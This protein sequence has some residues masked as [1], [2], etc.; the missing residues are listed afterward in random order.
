MR[1]PFRSPFPALLGVFAYLELHRLPVDLP[2]DGV[3]LLGGVLGRMDDDVSVPSTES[4]R[5]S[6][7]RK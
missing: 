7:W 3:G 5:R 1:R 6:H 4:P 2:L